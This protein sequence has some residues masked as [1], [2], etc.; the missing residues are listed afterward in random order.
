MKNFKI[1]NIILTDLNDEKLCET[2]LDYDAT[3]IGIGAEHDSIIK[4]ENLE[5][6]NGN[7][8]DILSEFKN[9]DAIFIND[10]PNWYT[11]Y[12][13]L[14]IVKK[15][16]EEFP[17]VFIC[18]NK[19]PNKR[20]DTYFNPDLIPDEFKHDFRK[21]LPFCF[22]DKQIVISDGYYHACE[23]NTAKNGV[24]TAIEDF[25]SENNQ[26]AVMKINFIDEITILYPK[27]SISDIRL[28]L[29]NEDIKGHELNNIDFS[30]KIIENN[31][32]LNY[33]DEYNISQNEFDN[34]SILK[35]EIS[36]KDNIIDDYVNKLQIQDLELDFKDNQIKNIK[37]KLDLKDSQIDN[38]KS[39]LFN[40]DHI[41]QTNEK[42]LL[43]KDN[44]IKRNE[45]ELLDK[46]NLIKRNEAELL[47]KERIINI[48]KKELQTEK[49]NY[50][51]LKQQH[52]IKLSEIDTKKYCISCYKEEISNN[53]LEIEY[54]KNRGRI[55]KKAISFLE[56]LVLI[57]KSQPSEIAINF[58]L[59]KLIKNSR[60]FDIG[61]YLNN[62]KDIQNSKWCKYFSPELHYVCFGFKEK[63]KFNKKYFNTS[64]KE[65]LLDYIFKCQD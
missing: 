44:L 12:N 4:K 9:F 19:F 38:Y 54:L 32:L 45:A 52:Y 1:N 56:Y 47:D 15:N 49:E 59:F 43:D 53:H 64:S 20:R 55:S 2:L 6:V 18:N 36:Q 28:S 65:Q 13:E 33:I 11:I 34:I 31:V 37:T 29:L 58:K 8:L 50:D 35:S 5:I 62:N 41:I 51:Y 22:N 61:Y 14:N 42:K 57:F 21:E 24:L 16:N 63:R 10:D 48:H 17:L 40:K 23:E 7:P 3:F 25:L 39:K 27:S 30:D 60:C 46:D 26:I